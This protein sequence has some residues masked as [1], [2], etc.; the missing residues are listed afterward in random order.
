VQD[1]DEGFDNCDGKD[2]VD[3]DLEEIDEGETDSVVDFG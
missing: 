1:E 2:G 3:S